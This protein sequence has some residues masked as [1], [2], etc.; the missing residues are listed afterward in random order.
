MSERM[1]ETL[2]KDSFFLR[3]CDAIPPWRSNSKSASF[4]CVQD[5]MKREE[6]IS[7][8]RTDR[9]GELNFVGLAV[10][11]PKSIRP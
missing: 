9:L 7:T 5:N 6:L 2:S 3:V 10:R 1:S 8:W 4:L 11:D